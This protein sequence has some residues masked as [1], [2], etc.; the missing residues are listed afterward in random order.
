[1]RVSDRRRTEQLLAEAKMPKEPKALPPEQSASG[2][3]SGE[4]TSAH[5]DVRAGW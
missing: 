2:Q 3:L 1:M 5:P 4:P